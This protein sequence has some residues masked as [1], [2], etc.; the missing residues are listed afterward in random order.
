MKAT[1]NLFS[2]SRPYHV[3]PKPYLFL[4]N[5]IK[6][7]SKPPPFFFAFDYESLLYVLF[8]AK[9]T[10]VELQVAY[11]AREFLGTRS[12]KWTTVTALLR[13]SRTGRPVLPAL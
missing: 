12:S 7:Y 11:V 9:A 3:S 4:K 10:L 6:T 1:M 5:K 13:L 2:W 8:D